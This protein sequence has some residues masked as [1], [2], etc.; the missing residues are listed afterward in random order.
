MSEDIGSQRR[1][2]AEEAKIREAEEARSLKERASEYYEQ[3]RLRAQEYNERLAKYEGLYDEA[4][5]GIA[6]CFCTVSTVR[7]LAVILLA[8]ST[9]V[10]RGNFPVELLV[11]VFAYVLVEAI[12]LFISLRLSRE[13]P[14]E[15]L[16]HD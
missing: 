16:I 8:I 1:E 2:T 3:G 9:C 13:I 12:H 14:L 4:G 11:M 15:A 6:L 7:A 5:T 10:L